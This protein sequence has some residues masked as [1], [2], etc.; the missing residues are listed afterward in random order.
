MLTLRETLMK[1]CNDAMMQIVKAKGK[2]M[3]F[4]YQTRFGFG[5]K[6]GIDLP[7]EEA[8]IR[9][10]LKSL[11]EI[12][13]AISS[14]GQTFNVTMIQLA[15]AYS[16]LVNGGYH[17]TPHVMKQVLND[18]GATVEQLDKVLVRQTVSK[19]TSKLIQDYMYHT[20]EEGTAQ[21][22]KVPGYKIGGKTGTAQKIPRDAGTYLVS[23][24]GSV[25]AYNPEL[26]IYVIIDEPQNV[27]RQDDSSLATKL[28]GRILKEI[29]PFAGIYPE[30]DIDY[31]LPGFEVEQ[32]SE[33]QNSNPN[34][35]NNATQNNN[36]N[37]NNNTTQNNNENPNNNEA[38]PNGEQPTNQT[39]QLGATDPNTN[40]QNELNNTETGSNEGVNGEELQ[41]LIGEEEEE[42]FNGEAI[43][44]IDE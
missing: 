30:G 1:S 44:S 20:V 8:G 39:N 36:T 3:F 28:A 22:A 26:V 32:A 15:A 37:Q 13:L 19:E 11:K 6:T 5:S 25:P 43:E 16:S 27:T 31:M 33:N 7:G 2:D 17:Y 9:R 4:D 41:N 12:D 29:L 34:Q 10:D 38:I 42:T 35:N 24:I 21:G 23:F 14:F 18:S 40:S